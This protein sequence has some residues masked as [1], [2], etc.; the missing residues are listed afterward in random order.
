MFNVHVYVSLY[1]GDEM[2]ILVISVLHDELECD[3]S[4]ITFFSLC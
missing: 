4:L 3:V 2:K 1:A